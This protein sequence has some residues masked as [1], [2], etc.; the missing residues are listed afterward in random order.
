MARVTRGTEL[1]FID[2]TDDTTLVKL[3]CPTAITGL[4]APREQIETTCLEDQARSYEAGLATPGQASVTVQFDPAEDSHIALYDL[5]TS[6]APPAKWAIGWSD[7]VAPPTVAAGDFVFPT[8][9]TF[10]TFDATVNSVPFDFSLN[11]VVQSTIP[12]QI[13]GMPEL[14]PKA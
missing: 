4:D 1:W 12:M 11:A 9:R 8:T 13:S 2:P 10:S 7:G 3:A 6:G 5:W 14:H